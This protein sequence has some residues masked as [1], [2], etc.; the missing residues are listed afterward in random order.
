MS[1]NNYDM[2]KFKNI[3]KEQQYPIGVDQKKTERIKQAID[4]LKDGIKNKSIYNVDYKDASDYL[5]RRYEEAIDDFENMVNGVILRNSRNYNAALLIHSI[6]GEYVASTMVSYRKL[7][8]NVQSFIKNPRESFQTWDSKSNSEVTI[9]FTEEHV[10]IA[11][12]FLNLL[13]SWGEAVSLRKEAK[14]YI[15]KGRKNINPGP[16]AYQ[17]PPQA[18]NSLKI[19]SSLLDE[20]T[21]NNRDYLIETFSNRFLQICKKYL[22]ERKDEK[23]SPWSFFKGP[24]ATDVDAILT[25]HEEKRAVRSRADINWKLSEKSKEVISRLSKQE[26]D[27]IIQQFINKNTSKLTSIIGEKSK[28]AQL[29]DAKNTESSV[30][31]GALEGWMFFSFDDDTSFNVNNKIVFGSSKYGRLFYRFPTTFHNVKTKDGRIVAM[32]SEEDM[33]EVWAKQ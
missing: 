1:K 7:V 32:V 8:Q 6:V 31:R 33:N 27:M 15:V 23:E 18:S 13:L 16:P 20:L 14:Q 19:V 17:P 4:I 25:A 21:R 9:K 26:A 3:L 22:S 11:K 10:N 5:S 24:P 28:V 2:I 12:E 30:N 29:V